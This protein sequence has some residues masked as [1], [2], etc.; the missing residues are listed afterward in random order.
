M[1]RAYRPEQQVTPSAVTQIEGDRG[2]RGVTFQGQGQGRR[3]LRHRDQVQPEAR[4]GI[5]RHRLQ[6]G[7][8]IVHLGLGCRPPSAVA[9]VV[10]GEHL[11]VGVSHGP[12][13]G[14]EGRAPRA[15][16]A[17]ADRELFNVGVPGQHGAGVVAHPAVVHG[18]QAAQ[19]RGKTFQDHIVDLDPPL[20]G[21]ERQGA[22]LAEA[23]LR[24]PNLQGQHQGERRQGRYAPG[25]K[26]RQVVTP[27]GDG[28]RALGALGRPAV[29]GCCHVSPLAL[30]A[31]GVLETG[32]RESEAKSLIAP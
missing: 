18:R 19:G 23:L 16:D 28:L 20:Q 4:Q 31:G 2:R 12:H 26:H 27:S 13:L 24:I 29:C 1:A 11:V 8:R 30:Q 9:V 3:H 6:E 32:S 5:C 15:K 7:H 10:E 17:G 22:T 25:P 14:L 21:R